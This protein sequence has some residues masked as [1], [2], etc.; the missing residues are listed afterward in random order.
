MQLYTSCFRIDV[1]GKEAQRGCDSIK[2]DSSDVRRSNWPKSTIR[3]STTGPSMEA[4]AA[5]NG[6]GSECPAVSDCLNGLI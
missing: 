3:L 1:N 2:A 6:G 5:D 4:M